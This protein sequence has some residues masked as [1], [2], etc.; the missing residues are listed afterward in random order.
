MAEEQNENAG[1]FGSY[2][3][4]R[5]AAKAVESLEPEYASRD[6]Q[7]ESEDD[8]ADSDDVEEEQADEDAGEP[9]PEAEDDSEYFDIDGSSVSFDELKA[10]YS[11]DRGN[12]Q[13]AQ[14]L[15]DEKKRMGEAQTY[16][17]NQ[18]QQYVQ[19]LEALN[20][21]L[22]DRV[23][24]VDKTELERLRTEDPMEYFA[25]R[26]E[27]RETE[28]EQKRIQD[29]IASEKTKQTQEH[30]SQYTDLLKKEAEAL[31]G[32]LPEWS[33]PKKGAALRNQ[34]KTY[35]KGQGYQDSEVDNIADH[36]A[37]VILRKAMLYDGIKGADAG[38]KKTRNAPRVQRPRGS[39]RVAVD[40]D[41]RNKQRKAL[42]S[43]GKVD[44]A[45]RVLF[46]MLE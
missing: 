23:E 33:D 25:K 27:L 22:E 24:A 16:L 21:R 37:I 1:I 15:S 11:R 9:E 5:E 44:D 38:N 19:A 17:M 31:K 28:N 8:T 20:K 14:T 40:S 34:L 12:T 3:D 42:R 45:A 32:V 43:S 35:A 13:Q 30:Q 7:T 6:N 10:S 2:E 4:V 36:R 46:D 26:D 29:S 39:G 18:S 41:K